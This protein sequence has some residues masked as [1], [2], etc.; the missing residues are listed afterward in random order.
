MESAVV[1]EP[2]DIVQDGFAGLIAGCE[3]VVVKPFVLQRT[4]KRFGHRIIPA[5]SRR[6][7][8]LP[9]VQRFKF[10]RVAVRSVLVDSIGGRN[11]VG[12]LG[13]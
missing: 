12:L 10:L 7:N 4:E 11:T 2:F 6:S 3:F 5:D 9:N 8:G 1:V 13:V